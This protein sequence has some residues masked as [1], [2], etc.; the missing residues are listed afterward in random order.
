MNNSSRIFDLSGV[1]TEAGEDHFFGVHLERPRWVVFLRGKATRQ[2]HLDEEERRAFGENLQALDRELRE[3]RLGYQDAAR[4]F[5]ELLLIAIFRAILPANINPQPNPLVEEILAVIDKRYAEPLSLRQ[6]ASAVGRSPSYV[7]SVVRQQ[8]GLTVLEWIT[9]R[10][11]EEARRRL[12][13]TDEDVA[14]VAERVGYVTTNHFLRQFRRAH[15][16]PPGAWRRAL[17]HPSGRKNR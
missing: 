15:G 9:E 6:V 3:R 10:R 1:S 16:Q 17:F 8:T 11:M 14:I 4:A 7:T 13:E 2:V 5:L 12:R